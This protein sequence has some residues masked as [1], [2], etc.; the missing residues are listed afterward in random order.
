MIILRN[1]RGGEGVTFTVT[2]GND[3]ITQRI[4]RPATVPEAVINLTATRGPCAEATLAWQAP[5]DGGSP[6][7]GYRVER[8]VFNVGF[9]QLITTAPGNATAAT[10]TGLLRL[11]YQFRVAAINA[12]GTGPYSNIAVVDGFTLGA[13]TNLT[14]TRNP[15]DTVNL[16]W[17]PPTQSECV[18]VA[19]YR[20]EYRNAS[21]GSYTLGATVAGNA[22]S[23][24]ISGLP[25][26]V[27]LQFRVGR[28][29]DANTTVYSGTVI[30]GNLP[31]SPSAPT[32]T[33]G[34]AAGSVNLTWTAQETQCFENTNY[35]VQFRPSTTTAWSDFARPQST[36]NG[37]TVTGLT[38]GVSYF[39]RVRA[40]NEVGTGSFSSE[41]G[42]I[43][44]PE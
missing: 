22:T 13:P 32:A 39:F 8:R 26:N 28:V 24:S 35:N 31:F 43:T 41:S 38:P 27:V 16:S 36:V 9:Y 12:L 34:E 20:L 42:S 10:L 19:S 1:W 7:T 25:T 14:F 37:A 30:S 40:V 2:C 6:I 11:G 44:I 4:Q 17:T 33:L 15:C 18:V 21:G 3:T 23:G 5:F 29:D